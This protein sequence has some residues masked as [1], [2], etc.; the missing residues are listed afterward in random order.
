[1]RCKL[2]NLNK[3]VG[4][5]KAIQ[6]LEKEIADLEKQLYDAEGN[7]NINIENKINSDKEQI[8]GYERLI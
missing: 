7:I 6:D 5:I 2:N 8:T 4:Y 3:I 1:M